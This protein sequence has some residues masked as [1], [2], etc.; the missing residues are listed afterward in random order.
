[1]HNNSHVNYGFQYEE[2]PPPY[3]PPS[4]PS[5]YSHQNEY[6]SVPQ[7]RT[8]QPTPINTHQTVTPG[9]PHRSAVRKVS[10]E[11]RC[12]C[13]TTV[14]I[15]ILVILAV[16]AVLI[17]YFLAGVCTRKCGQSEQCIS[18]SQW[19][20][21]KR[22]CFDGEDEAH[23]F[24][25]YGPN[26]LLQS[27][28]N[29][30]QKWKW[31]CSMGWNKEVGR[32]TCMQ[33]G[34]S[35]DD[36]V[37]ISSWSSLASEGSDGFMQL[38]GDGNPTH[39]YLNDSP[40][41]SSNTVVK[42]KCV[43]CGQSTVRTRIVGGD[44]VTSTSR[45]PWQVSLHAKGQHLC[46]GSIISS[47][48][49]ISAAHCF[50]TLSHPS[51]WTVYAGYLT[52]SEM[53]SVSGRTVFRIISH[54]GFDPKTNDNDIAMMKLSSRF[55]M[56]NVGPVCL[57]NVGVS[58]SAQTEC[59]ITGWGALSSQGPSPDVLQ[60]ARVSVIDRS[61]CNSPTVY[62]GQITQSMICAGRLQGGVDS[63]QGDSGGPLVSQQGS[64]WWLVGDTSWGQGCALRNKP[65]VYGNI[66]FFLDWIQEQ[67]QRY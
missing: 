42:L 3:R 16:A 8:S 36:F 45:W 49:I 37:E 47:L 22:D 57:P 64:Q 31:V 21:G 4:N 58:F 62:N 48:W 20:D 5:S 27:Y 38:V 53:E 50:Q 63:C 34:Y 39:S 51:Q 56:P 43:A 18:D 7:Y 12:P 55:T 28:S 25:V 17:W 61:I 26:F 11:S 54:P 9:L 40:S 66:T 60:E 52:Q 59:Y 32:Q 67:M 33:M 30:D 14:V 2:R 15:F 13:I 1:M 24:R 10:R 29:R 41:C 35:S 44:A 19:C 6:P 23:C 65:G 46:G